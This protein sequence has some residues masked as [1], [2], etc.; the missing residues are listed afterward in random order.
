MKMKRVKFTKKRNK[1]RRKNKKFKIKFSII[2]LILILVIIFILLLYAIKL[3]IKDNIFEKYDPEIM[4]YKGE[5]VQKKKL[6]EDFLTFSLDNDE[7]KLKEKNLLYKNLYLD[8]Y[9]RNTKKIAEIK[10]KFIS[11]MKNNQTKK[12]DI[13]YLR[14]NCQLG[15]FRYI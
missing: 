1:R 4:T 8:D 10:T 2:Y 5:K 3:I 14:N 13:F 11:Q 6:I 9:P 12:I 15:N 7:S